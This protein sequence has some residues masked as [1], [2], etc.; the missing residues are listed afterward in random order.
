MVGEQSLKKFLQG[1]KPV[2]LEAWFRNILQSYPEEAQ[3]FLQKKE[4]TFTNPIGST[5]HEALARLLEE[6]IEDQNLSRTK[7]TLDE[8]IH[9]RAVQ[10][11]SPA[12]AISFLPALKQ[13][14]IREL[15]AANLMDTYQEEYYNLAFLID[16]LT[17]Q[18]FD[19]YMG[20]REKIFKLKVKELQKVIKLQ[21]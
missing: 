16:E 8:L 4:D 14:I 6:I 15:R 2:I 5:I 7:E 3:P 1:K 17:M 13:I 12:Q 9:L 18:A 11:Y 10:D 19:I 21:S 20:C